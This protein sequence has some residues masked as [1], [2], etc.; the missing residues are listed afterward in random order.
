[1]SRENI[2][3]RLRVNV[4]K[5]IQI[6]LE[7]MMGDMLRLMED[8]YALG[9]LADRIKASV[10][11]LTGLSNQLQIP[12]IDTNQ[13][14]SQILLQLFSTPWGNKPRSF[15]EIRN[16]LNY[17]GLQVRKTTLSG[18]LVWL[19]KKGKLKRYKS[20]EGVWLYCLPEARENE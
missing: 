14:L 3:L 5:G 20:N 7:G 13:R 1:M 19:T 11:H 15:R 8:E 9:E 4:L 2:T 10:H 12:L 17:I 6:E 18:L 16:A